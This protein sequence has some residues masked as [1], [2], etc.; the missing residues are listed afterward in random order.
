MDNKNFYTKY[1]NEE[2]KENAICCNCGKVHTWFE[3]TCAVYN[4][5]FLCEDCYNDYFGYCNNCGELFK[6]KDM[7]SEIICKGCEEL[8]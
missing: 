5:E 3:D 6:Y 7:N 2:E 8:V 4:G 1:N